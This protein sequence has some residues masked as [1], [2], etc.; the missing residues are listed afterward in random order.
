MNIH[1]I[2]WKDS[3]NLRCNHPL[4]PKSI[5]AVIVGKSGCGKTTL[6]LNL[7]LNPR[8]LDYNKLFVFGKS[9]FQ[10][11]YQ[12]IK[13]SFEEGLPKYC[14][15][16]I[17]RMNEEIVK[18]D[19][20]DV[21]DVIHGMAKELP[22]KSDIKV[23]Y[24]EEAEDVPDPGDLSK[25][26]KNLLIFDD[27]ILTKQNKIEDY[28]TRGRHSNVDCIYLSQNYFKLPRQT[29]RENANLFI[30]FPQDLKNINHIFNDHVSEDMEK[31]EFRSLCRSAWRG[32]YSFLTIDLSSPPESGRYRI[33]FD[34]FYIPKRYEEIE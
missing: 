15:L 5:R 18:N 22:I 23:E 12:I 6:L 21:D 16:N 9:L 20:C 10:S 33:N 24:F 27:L 4:L 25:D 8:Y 34:D 30:L 28:Y 19:E 26:D 32:S 14:I 11:E 31:A 13:K 7:L 1:N 2:S 17:F 29:I 3:N